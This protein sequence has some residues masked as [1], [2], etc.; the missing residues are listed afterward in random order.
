MP[1]RVRALLALALLVTPAAARAQARVTVGAAGVYGQPL[2]QFGNSVK[3]AFGL[4]GFGTLGVDP[5]GIFSLRAEL[6]YMQY[7]TK[8][9]PFFLSTGGGFFELESET[10][11][12]VFT[13]GIGPQLS[14]PA[15]PVRPYVAG[16]V[17]FARFA[18]NTSIN[19][20]ARISNTGRKRTLDQRTV[21]SDFILSLAGSAGIAF[22]LSAF[23]NSGILVDI[24][25]RYHRNGQARYV[26]SEGV[27][28]D[29]SATP[30][31]TPTESE[32]NF[33]V[34]RLGVVFP[35]R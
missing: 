4:D 16:T 10:K 29:G 26:S 5:Q 9:E 15:G 25:A 30:I 2:G 6:G 33:L 22:H 12:G 3:R 8:T 20:P 7:S 19:V 14:V 23:G 11:S 24:G 21:S 17:G 18:T 34:Y 28:Y 1:H 32:A 13:L 35:I 27:Q 31:I